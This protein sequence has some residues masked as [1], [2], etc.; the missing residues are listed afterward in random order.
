MFSFWA[1]GGVRSHVAH[2]D[3]VSIWVG[4]HRPDGPRSAACSGDILDDNPLTER[5]RHV[6]ADDAGSHVGPAS[7]SK[8]NDYGDWARRKWLGRRSFDACQRRDKRDG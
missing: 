4:T 7:R 5:A 2:Y 1:F 3:R 8:R 6:F